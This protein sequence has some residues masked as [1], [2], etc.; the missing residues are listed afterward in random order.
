MSSRGRAK[1]RQSKSLGK[2]SPS[3]TSSSASSLPSPKL[4]W[5]LLVLSFI[6]GI[7]FGCAL[8]KGQVVQ[9]NVI[10]SQFLFRKFVM[11]KMF[12][13]AV[14]S[15]LTCIAL[16]SV[17]PFFKKAWNESRKNFLAGRGLLS[18]G[19]GATLLGVGMG[20]SGSCPGSAYV[21]LGAGLKNAWA[22]ICGGFVAVYVFSLI[23]PFL[24]YHLW[25]VSLVKK[26]FLD[27]M[28][29]KP[30]IVLAAPM[31]A[32]LV[33]VIG[34][35]EWFFPYDE[36]L[37]HPGK[38]ENGVGVFSFIAW[39]PYV[40]GMIVGVL[41]IPC[42]IFLRDTL[43]SASSYKTMFSNI[44]Y[45]VSKGLV[46]RSQWLESVRSGT[47]NWWQM[48]YVW[49]VVVGGFI[50]ATSS[51]TFGEMTGPGVIASLIGGFFIVF[52][53]LIA[54]GCTTGHG[55]S[56]LGLMATTS[57]LAIPCMFAGAISTAIVLRLF[58]FY[59]FM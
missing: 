51:E 13:S 55:I 44:A 49:G 48:V 35:L 12:L 39:P 42:I 15:S 1:Q 8:Q 24:K 45:K 18:V 38:A 53:P 5:S 2:S 6:M 25:S 54:A 4:Q 10:V 40:T 29:G 30:F 23:E 36:E 56:G 7:V 20:I 34:I 58:G 52:G 59:H 17:V 9:P 57:F 19:I 16:V 50:G 46:H 47:S 31:V 33:C 28:Y 3:P 43:G 41:Q 37:G 26:D 11:M 27:L 32:A 21:Q 22:L 14:A